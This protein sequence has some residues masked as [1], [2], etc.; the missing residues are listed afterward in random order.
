[1]ERKK[2]RDLDCSPIIIDRIQPR[3]T[4]TGKQ[5]LDVFMEPLP[6]AI[7]SIFESDYGRLMAAGIPVNEI[8]D[9]GGTHYCQILVEWEYDEK[10]KKSGNK[11]RKLVSAS[12]M[13]DNGNAALVKRLDRM[14]MLMAEQN[15]L[16]SQIIAIL[17]GGEFAAQ[18]AVSPPPPQPTPAP[19]TA[20]SRP[21]P[22]SAAN[23][24]MFYHRDQAAA[25]E[26]RDH[27]FAA[28]FA[29]MTSGETQ[30]CYGAQENVVAI[31]DLLA[32]NWQPGAEKHNITML[33][34]LATY[35]TK[36]REK[37]AAGADLR[38]AHGHGLA[39]AGNQLRRAR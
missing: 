5:V 8:L 13:V 11:Y 27:F 23:H 35:C 20:V 6:H 28:V 14:G 24:D 4:T 9:T 30:S 3:K 32:P 16:L 21:A 29:Y 33:D 17:S 15:Q 12:S 38:A 22:Q 7:F 1:M 10:E 25:A 36:R 18:T 26:E 2:N 19:Q 37:E 31:A 34:A 39:E